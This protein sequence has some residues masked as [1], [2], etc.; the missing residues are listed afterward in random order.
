MTYQAISEL[1]QTPDLQVERANAFIFIITF[2]LAGLFILAILYN[3]HLSWG[4]TKN[5]NI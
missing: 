1:L 2:M 4:K 5:D 3:I